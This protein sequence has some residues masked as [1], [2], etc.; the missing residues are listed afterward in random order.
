MIA[1]AV[2]VLAHAGEVETGQSGTIAFTIMLVTVLA[3]VW[4]V[5][6]VVVWIFWR[7]KKREDEAL[8]RGSRTAS[9]HPGR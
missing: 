9:H 8:R 1:R 3:I 5:L 7:A 6:G 2:A 4:I